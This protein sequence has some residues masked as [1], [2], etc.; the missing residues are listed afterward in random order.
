MANPSQEMG[1]FERVIERGSFAGAAQD[2]GLSPS[3][4][5]KLITRLEQ[6]LGVRLI[7]RTT[8]RLAL[9]AEG[10]IY[11]RRAREILDAINAAESEIAS[12]RTSPRGHLRVL[13][14]PVL[15]IDHLGPA[16]PDFFAR[17]PRITLDFLVTNRAVD[18]IG[19][20]VDIALRTGD[21]DDSSL[22]ARKIVDLRRVICA[23]PKYLARNGRP[24]QPSDLSHHACLTLSRLPQSAIWSFRVNDTLMPVTVRGPLS[25]DSADMLVKLAIEGA[26]IVRLGEI[27]VANAIQN[28]LLEPLLQDSHESE[29]FPL[30]AV[31]PPGRQRTLKVRVFLDFLIELFGSASWRLIPETGRPEQPPP[32]ARSGRNRRS[33]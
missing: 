15:A 27:A 30:W 14:P 29:D 32:N 26:G 5:S 19:E 20:N 31:M 17:H 10:E 7:T 11:L 18:L 23:S 2:V 28:G 3:A 24:I 21:L 9:T 22:V 12:A 13:A 1:V 4:V 6:R 25:A 8:R 33:P 16:L